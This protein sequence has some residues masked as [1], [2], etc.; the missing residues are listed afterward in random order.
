VEQLKLIKL[1]CGDILLHSVLAVS[2]AHLP[3]QQQAGQEVKIYTPEEE[4][5]LILS[6]S[7]MGFVYISEV[8]ELKRRM[9][10]LSPNPGKLPKTFLVMGS[11]KWLDG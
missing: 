8:D 7:I 3:G 9:T 1:E 10:V 4:S 2:Y 6:S 5:E 11:L